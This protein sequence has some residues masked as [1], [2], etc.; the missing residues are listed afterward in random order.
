[1]T[2]LTIIGIVVI[3][4]SIIMSWTTVQIIR[5][6]ELKPRI[7]TFLSILYFVATITMG[8]GFLLITNMVY[9]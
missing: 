2:K 3:V 7:K 8:I 9:E 1:M 6:V 5:N 4:I